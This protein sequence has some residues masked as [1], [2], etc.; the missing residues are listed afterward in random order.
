MKGAFDLN[1]GSGG[2]K[3]P[4]NSFTVFKQSISLCFTDYVETL[5][6]LRNILLVMAALLAALII[7]KD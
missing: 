7:L 6:Y 1:L 5:G 2:G 4:C 3:L